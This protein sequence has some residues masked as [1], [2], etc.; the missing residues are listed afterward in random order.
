M[1]SRKKGFTLIELLVVISIIALLVSILMPALGKAKRHGWFVMCKNNLR[2]TGL[3][4]FMYV[5]D[6]SDYFTDAAEFMVKPVINDPG[7]PSGCRWHDAALSANIRPELAGQLWPYLETQDIAMCPAFDSVSRLTKFLHN[8]CPQYFPVEPQYAFSQNVFLGQLDQYVY[9]N[10]GGLRRYET[11]SKPWVTHKFQSVKRPAEVFLFTEEGPIVLFNIVVAGVNIQW[12]NTILNDTM[13]FPW[14][15]ED[16]YDPYN[17]CDSAGSFHQTSW[18]ST[19]TLA[20]GMA[21]ALFVDGHVDTMYPWET[22]KYSTSKLIL[23]DSPH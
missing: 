13:I 7:H 3:A 17:V 23:K 5:Q 20:G 22:K 14:F 16:P 2:Q 10:D 9:P 8:G 15:D 21:N 11:W 4:E 18:T 6:N 12:N 19:E 1:M